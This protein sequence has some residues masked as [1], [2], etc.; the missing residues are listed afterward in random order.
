MRPRLQRQEHGHDS[1]EGQSRHK[2][3]GN[4]ADHRPFRE[5]RLAGVKNG[6][7]GRLTNIFDL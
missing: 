7:S 1:N 2:V 3:G 4:Y 6:F 5:K